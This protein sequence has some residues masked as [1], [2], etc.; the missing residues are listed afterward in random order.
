MELETVLFSANFYHMSFKK[1]KI[2]KIISNFKIFI[3]KFRKYKYYDSKVR[4]MRVVSC[5]TRYIIYSTCTVHAID[6]NMIA[7][8]P[9]KKL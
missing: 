4:I 3:I 9:K 5:D 1:I 2:P 6:L 8:T 7:Q